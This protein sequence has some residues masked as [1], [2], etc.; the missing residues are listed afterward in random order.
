MHMQ[1][2]SSVALPAGSGF[3]HPAWAEGVRPDYVG[4]RRDG[5]RP[6]D[7]I[8]EVIP[9][10]LEMVFDKPQRGQ[11]GPGKATYLRQVQVER[12]ILHYRHGA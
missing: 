1:T 4:P 7:G 8:N 2:N 12:G 6:C 11:R 10:M 9:A 3:T 5:T